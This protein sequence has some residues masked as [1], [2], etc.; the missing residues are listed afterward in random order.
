MNELNQAYRENKEVPYFTPI[1][2]PMVEPDDWD[3]WWKIWNENFDKLF[4]KQYFHSEERVPTGKV[5]VWN[6]IQ[7]Y[8][9]TDTSQDPT[10]M[11]FPVVD[12]R[13]SLPKMYDQLQELKKYF[14][15]KNINFAFIQ[16]LY[17]IKPHTD[18]NSNTW[19]ARQFFYN[20]VESQQ[21]YFTKPFDK[22]GETRTYIKMPEDTPW[23]GFNDGLAWHGTDFDEN[24]K[25]ILLKVYGTLH[26]EILQD[27]MNKYK[28]YVLCQ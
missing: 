15:G 18:R 4:K 14:L 11:T 23:F 28:D 26:H 5:Q 16:S 20:P 9:P 7:V 12:I 19:M 24:R 2:L 3:V 10:K 25:K 1:N 17:P 21:W 13:N 8:D 6:G 27:S 22:L